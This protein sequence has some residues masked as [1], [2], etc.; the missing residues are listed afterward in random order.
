MLQ[1]VS[2]AAV[3]IGALSVKGIQQCE[4]KDDTSLVKHLCPVIEDKCTK[5]HTI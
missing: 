4:I 1:N 5:A 3:V 2:S